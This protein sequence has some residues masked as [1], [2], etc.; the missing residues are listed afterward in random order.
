MINLG[1]NLLQTIQNP[2]SSKVDF[3]KGSY[4][5]SCIKITKDEIVEYG[6]LKSAYIHLLNGS[7]SI[8][9]GDYLKKLVAEGDTL[10]I[11]NI[12]TNMIGEADES[13]LLLAGSQN[14]QFQKSEL[15]LFPLNQLKKVDKPWGYE[16]W[17]TGEHPGYCLKKIFI[18]KGARTSLQ[19]HRQ[20]RETNVLFKGM[21]RL[22]FK[23]QSDVDND[24]VTTSDLAFCELSPMSTIDVGPNTL[25]RIEAVTDITLYEVST[26]QLDDVIRVS[27]DTNRTD[28][29]IKA[30][31]GENAR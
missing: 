4:F 1:G 14:Q 6:H 5:Y 25:H 3:A 15:N 31:H 17:I 30:E 22:Y 29:R 23:S 13:Y 9:S 24:L 16:V 20:K 26:P 28:G 12:E 8:K 2:I 21:A 18:K 19:Y 11:E 27:D 10:Q 7:V